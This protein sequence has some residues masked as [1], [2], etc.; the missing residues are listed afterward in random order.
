MET[1]RCEAIDDLLPIAFMWL[2]I[3]DGALYTLGTPT[4]IAE[5]E[6]RLLIII[7]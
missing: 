5:A 1:D 3:S 2:F 7:C 4:Y 6:Y